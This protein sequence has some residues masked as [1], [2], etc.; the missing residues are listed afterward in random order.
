[1]K[2]KKFYRK[3]DIVFWFIIMSLPIIIF[4]IRYV[5]L[6][7][8]GSHLTTLS[9]VESLNGSISSGTFTLS[10]NNNIRVRT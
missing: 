2:A 6:C 4:L 10:I 7:F 5:G 9:D 8:S 1:M 3:C